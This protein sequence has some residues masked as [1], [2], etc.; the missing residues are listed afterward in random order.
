M[1][2]FPFQDLKTSFEDCYTGRRRECTYVPGQGIFTTPFGG[3]HYS[4]MTFYCGHG[5]ECN[6]F[7]GEAMFKK[8]VE[9]VEKYFAV[10]RRRKTRN[11]ALSL[12]FLTC[13]L[14]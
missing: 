13:Q 1:V 4:Q 6:E 3:S 14:H 10:V 2:L 5:L 9:N 11:Q 7:E 12:T 8:A